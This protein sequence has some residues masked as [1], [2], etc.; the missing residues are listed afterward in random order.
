MRPGPAAARTSTTSS[1]VSS[2]VSSNRRGITSRGHR[3]HHRRP[4]PPTM[5]PTLVAAAARRAAS[6]ASSLL[7]RFNPPSVA[8]AA[9]IATT[10]EAAAAAA[11]AA[12]AASPALAEE[13]LTASRSGGGSSSISASPAGSGSGRSSSSASTSSS[14]VPSIFS[15]RA[16]YAPHCAPWLRNSKLRANL[17]KYCDV[18]DV[19]EGDL[20]TVKVATLRAGGLSGA[21][22][23]GS[24]SGGSGASSPS[25]QSS[26]SPSLLASSPPRVVVKSF[27]KSKLLR[28]P[29]LQAKVKLEWEI[30]SALDHE[31]VV[32]A[33]LASESDAH[34]GLFMEFA[35]DSDAYSYMA[36]KKRLA[37]RED[38]A[39]ALVWDVLQALEH[40]HHGHGVVHRDIKSE[41]VF[42]C[43]SSG[44][45]KLGDFGSALRLGDARTM[46]RQPLKLEGTF[47][48]APPEYVAIWDRFTRAELLDATSF[49]LDTWSLGALAYDVLCGRAPFALRDD[50]PRAEEAEAILRAAPAF[51]SGLSYAAVGFMKQALEKDPQKRPTVRQLAAHPWFAG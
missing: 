23:G 42:R 44:C 33:Y 4:P 17:E 22:S 12:A 2:S 3:H 6:P 35:G 24:G 26:P 37:L 30:H 5:L 27:D 10:G 34:V 1:S 32:R 38:D 19:Y 40:L 36:A 28:R 46:A 45:W 13:T 11:G 49:R 51:P 31:N 48:F 9:S 41:N 25:L 20:S 39:R 18:R 50:I 21:E 7:G 29:D 47:S 43:A 15:A 8:C 16:K 14:S